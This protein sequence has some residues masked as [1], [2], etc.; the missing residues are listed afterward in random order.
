MGN[1]IVLCLDE[2]NISLGFYYP[3]AFLLP[4][5]VDEAFCLQT[6]QATAFSGPPLC[7][8]LPCDGFVWQPEVTGPPRPDHT[9]APAASPSRL[10]PAPAAIS[11]RGAAPPALRLVPL[12]DGAAGVRLH[13]GSRLARAAVTPGGGGAWRGGSP[14]GRCGR[15]CARAAAGDG[16]G[17]GL[18]GAAA[19]G[20]PRARGCPRRVHRGVW[21][22]WGPAGG[23]SRGYSVRGREV[24]AF[25]VSWLVRSHLEIVQPLPDLPVGSCFRES[26]VPQA[27]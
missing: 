18:C 12:A 13:A 27:G 10:P 22:P 19:P 23:D 24:S 8:F 11:R 21:G 20:A 6:I 1:I 17:H 3:R 26:R 16:G 9:P 25:G 15:S 4:A 7:G 5:V 2:E 14:R